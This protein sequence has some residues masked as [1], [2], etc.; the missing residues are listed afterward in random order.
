MGILAPIPQ[1]GK[2]RGAGDTDPEGKV[3][4]WGGGVP[5]GWGLS[6]LRQGGRGAGRQGGGLAMGSE[7]ARFSWGTQGSVRKEGRS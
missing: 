1:V 2:V 5:E 4:T 3:W 7:G 6:E